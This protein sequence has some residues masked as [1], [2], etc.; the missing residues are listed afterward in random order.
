MT[1]NEQLG[2]SVLDEGQALLCFLEVVLAK[3]LSEMSFS[4][5]QQVAVRKWWSFPFISMSRSEDDCVKSRC[6]SCTGVTPS[7]KILMH[8]GPCR[9]FLIS[10]SLRVFEGRLVTLV[11]G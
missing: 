6:L 5:F 9:I 11:T 10:L 4:A 1:R 3:H 8:M 7:M 2:C